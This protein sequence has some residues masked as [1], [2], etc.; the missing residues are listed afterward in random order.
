MREITAEQITAVVER[1]CIDSN[2]YLPQDVLQALQ[3]ARARETTLLG[4]DILDDVLKNAELA[5]TFDLPICQDTGLA[6]F[7]VEV[8]QEVH[9][10][11]GGLNEA[12]DEGVRCGYKNGYLRK[13]TVADPFLQRINIGDNTPAIIHLSIVPGDKIKLTIA[14]KGGGSENMSA[15][16]MLMPNAGICGMKSFVKQTVQQSGANACPPLI[17]GVGVGGTMEMAALIA[18]KALLR[19]IGQSHNN[20]QVAAVEQ[21]LLAEINDLGL[22]PQGL[23]GSITALAVHIETFPAHFASM[24]VAVNLQ[25]HVARHKEA[26]I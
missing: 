3:E 7:F 14:P 25:C 23:G 10:V 21:E 13:S 12:I 2:Y 1:L 26:L 22:G 18:K 15:L 11:N 19:T 16:A 8:G 24:P 4:R 9:I 17:V 5:R 20:P 6:V